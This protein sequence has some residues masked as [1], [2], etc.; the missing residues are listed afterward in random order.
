MGGLEGR[1]ALQSLAKLSE[2]L[3]KACCCHQRSGVIRIYNRRKR[4]ERHGDAEFLQ[5]L[6]GS[7]FSKQEAKGI[8][9]MSGGA[10]GVQLDRTPKLL[11][12]LAPPP[13]HRERTGTCGVGFGK[14]VVKGERLARSLVREQA[15]LPGRYADA[16]AGS[17][18]ISVRESGV[19]ERIGWVGCDGLLE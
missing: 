7:L 6:I 8:K 10:I 2:R 16:I 13:R 11:L 1:I 5:R 17:D 3:G 12:G 18:V 15:R 14:R 4:I 9:I 19:G